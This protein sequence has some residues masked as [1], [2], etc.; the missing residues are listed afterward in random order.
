MNLQDVE[1]MK[2]RG[3]DIFLKYMNSNDNPRTATSSMI[4]VMDDSKRDTLHWFKVIKTSEE[5]TEVSSGD[6]VLIPWAMTRGVVDFD[7]DEGE[8]YTFS[9][10]DQ[11]MLVLD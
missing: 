2:L 3:K 8:K 7:D 6:T 11:V 1:E 5:V 9:D 4:H 10:E